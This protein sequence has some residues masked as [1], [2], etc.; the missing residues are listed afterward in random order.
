MAGD[1][2]GYILEDDPWINDPDY[3][4]DEPPPVTILTCSTCFATPLFWGF[5]EKWVYVDSF[6]KRHVCPK[7]PP[8]L[9][10]FLNG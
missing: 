8:T 7:H 3:W 5:Y 4:D 9:K 10:E 6:N 2:A 1:M